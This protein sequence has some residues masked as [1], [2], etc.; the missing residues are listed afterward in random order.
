MS[1]KRKR[2]NEMMTAA[3]DQC[4]KSVN[5]NK[6]MNWPAT[7]STT[8]LP[9]SFRSDNCSAR[10]PAH[11]PANVTTTIAA[12]TTA[13]RSAPVVNRASNKK[14]PTASKE[15]NVPGASGKYPTPQVAIDNAR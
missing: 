14:I 15:P 11:I 10:V 7:S 13:T 3:V 4:E 1:K 8:T 9:G 5:G 12:S 6:A 2:I